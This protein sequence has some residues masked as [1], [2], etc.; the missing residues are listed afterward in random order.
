[1]CVCTQCKRRLHSHRPRT[2]QDPM[3]NFC[4]G[5]GHAICGQPMGQRGFPNTPSPQQHDSTPVSRDCCGKQVPVK[6]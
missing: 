3:S 5:G 6:V 2:L 4:V 1:M